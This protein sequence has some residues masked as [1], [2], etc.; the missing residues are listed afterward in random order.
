MNFSLEIKDERP[1]DP[2][3][4]AQTPKMS[5][6]LT[7]QSI[8]L[9]CNVINHIL[10]SIVSI[11]MTY[12][13][14][15]SGNLAISWHV[16]LCTI[17]FQLIY[18]QAIMAFYPQNLWS[19]QYSRK[20]QRTVHWILQVIGSSAAIIGITIEYIGRCQKSKN[21]FISTHSTI[22]LIAGIFM[23]GAMLGGISALWSTKLKQYVRPIYIKLAHNFSGI[24]VF[25]LGNFF[26]K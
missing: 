3:L 2:T 11:Y 20:T 8:Q 1:K 9:V 21:H 13:S 5:A 7:W 26:F 16:F 10:I 4:P 6:R 22:G 14:Y 23:L 12:I 25:V 17:G 24:T 18:C 15:S 19:K